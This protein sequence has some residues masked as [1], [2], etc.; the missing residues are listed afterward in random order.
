MRKRKQKSWNTEQ[1][2]IKEIDAIKAQQVAHLAEAEKQE[3][4]GK[5]FIR[6]GIAED[7]EAGKWALKQAGI[8]RRRVERLESKLVKFK[9]ALAEFR[10]DMLDLGQN[11]LDKQVVLK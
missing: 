4:D 5:R 10:T 1:A 2:L 7:I 9:D 8:A 3:D 6:S 11:K